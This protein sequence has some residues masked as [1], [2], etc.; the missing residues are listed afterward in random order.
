LIENEKA[1]K[2][3]KYTVKEFFSIKKWKHPQNDLSFYS[4]NKVIFSGRRH[5]REKKF[6]IF[7]FD[8]L[9]AK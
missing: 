5:L 3:I 9:I 1:A 6:G 2:F 4:Y 7:F 8:I